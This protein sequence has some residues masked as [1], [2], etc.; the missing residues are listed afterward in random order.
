MV[1]FILCQVVTFYHEHVLIK[2]PGANKKTPWHV[3]QTYYPIDG[4]K[5]FIILPV[6]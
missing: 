5:V 3:D 4:D 2:E 1:I 6:R